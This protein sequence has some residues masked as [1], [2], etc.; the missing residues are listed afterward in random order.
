MS[1]S[2]FA[3][4]GKAN[5][6]IDIPE[7][8]SS[9]SANATPEND[10]GVPAGEAFASATLFSIV[11]DCRNNPNEDVTFRLYDNAAPTVGTT[12]AEVWVR[13]K[14]GQL[15]EYEWPIGIPYGTG[16]SA[17]TVKGAGG[18]GGST[19]PSG[20]VKITLTCNLTLA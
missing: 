16:L 4:S 8:G 12:A 18:T 15:I 3:T 17:A 20:I 13:G 11:V 2:A 7:K 9:G 5:L 10:M 19:D 6:I 1:N 14:R